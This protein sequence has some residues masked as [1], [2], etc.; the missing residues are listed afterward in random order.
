MSGFKL[1]ILI[2]TL[3]RREHQFCK[4]MDELIEQA[5]EQSSI[6]S[7]TIFHV[8]GESGLNI[9]FVTDCVECLYYRDSGE[10]MTGFKRQKLLE[11]AKGEYIVFCDDDDSVPSYY[12]E[13]ILK[14][15]EYGCDCMGMLGVMT[16]NGTDRIE[17][18]LSKDFQNET[19]IRNGKKFYI[20]KTNHIAPVKRELAL[21]AGFEN[22][23]NGEDKNYSEKLNK[24][25]QT[26]YKM[27]YEMYHYDYQSG[28]KEYLK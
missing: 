21:K 19:I 22:I 7:A 15:V 13:E 1:S 23:S 6:K 12:I 5:R 9:A 24:Y 11:A 25:L 27:P 2:A 26:E 14:G 28:F 8:K 18:E 3:S 16:T 17:W 4:L 10:L 20:R